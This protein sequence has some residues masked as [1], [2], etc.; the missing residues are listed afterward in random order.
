MNIKP[1]LPKPRKN[2]N[3]WLGQQG[4]KCN[5]C[6]AAS[7][8]DEYEI[9]HIHPKSRGGTEDPQNFQILCS[10]CNSEKSFLTMRE[11][12][13]MP[14]SRARNLW[15][16]RE[17]EAPRGRFV[18][19]DDF[20]NVRKLEMRA[21]KRIGVVLDLDVVGPAGNKVVFLPGQTIEVVQ[22]PYG[23]KRGVVSFARRSWVWVKIEG[24]ETHW[25]TQKLPATICVHV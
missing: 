17:D 12:V 13:K 2:K 6:G 21:A 20:R 14:G 18:A 25:E 23:G 1:R 11:W 4:W 19:V 10:T 24:L 5:G 16:W 3:K 15:W 7:D 22:G 8:L 9:D